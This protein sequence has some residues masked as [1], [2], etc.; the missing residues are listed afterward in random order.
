MTNIWQMCM[1]VR[2]GWVG[3]LL[4]WLT[5]PYTPVHL[6]ACHLSCWADTYHEAQL[7]DVMRHHDIITVLSDSLVT[8]KYTNQNW[9]QGKCL[10]ADKPST[11]LLMSDCRNV[12]CVS[13]Q[14]TRTQVKPKSKKTWSTELMTWS[15][16]RHYAHHNKEDSWL[17]NWTPQ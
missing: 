3:G 15:T 8:C 1:K 13:S 11:V 6:P 4:V 7:K 2:V 12:C 14:T 17:L 16:N 5:G 10:N 9:N